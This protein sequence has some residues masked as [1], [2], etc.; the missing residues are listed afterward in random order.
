MAGLGAGRV[1][2]EAVAAAFNARFAVGGRAV[3]GR[4]SLRKVW[5][6]VGVKKEKEE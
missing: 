6:R 1:S 3:R 2:W 5:G 4:E